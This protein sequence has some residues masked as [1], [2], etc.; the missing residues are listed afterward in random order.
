VAGRCPVG[1]A[2]FRW[3]AIAEAAEYRLTCVQIDA[4]WTVKVHV[5]FDPETTSFQARRELRPGLWLCEA[6]SLPG[7]IVSN[8]EEIGG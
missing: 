8:Q 2:T 5:I 7:E 4:K 3:T 1:R 6:I